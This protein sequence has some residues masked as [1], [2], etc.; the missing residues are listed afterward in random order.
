VVMLGWERIVC[1]LR[2]E[3]S[4]VGSINKTTNGLA[5]VAEHA[6]AR[7]AIVCRCSGSNLGKARDDPIL[8]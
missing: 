8:R 2:G 1:G 3:S 5:D 7:N 4:H 6:R